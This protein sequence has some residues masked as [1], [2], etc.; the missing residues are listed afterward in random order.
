LKVDELEK[1][2]GSSNPI[3]PPPPLEAMRLGEAVEFFRI[4]L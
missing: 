2:G 4:Q 3:S 1:V